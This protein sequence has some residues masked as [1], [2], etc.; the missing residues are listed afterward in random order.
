MCVILSLGRFIVSP[1]N[2]KR[3]PKW[4]ELDKNVEFEIEES[5]KQDK[6]L[7]KL[8]LVRCWI[9]SGCNKYLIALLSTTNVD[10]L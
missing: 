5:F 7:D 6:M 4:N 2:L 9:Q 10:G 8:H 3:F 1:F